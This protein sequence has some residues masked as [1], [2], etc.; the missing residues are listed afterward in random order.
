MLSAIHHRDQERLYAKQVHNGRSELE[1]SPEE[2]EAVS[3]ALRDGQA[4]AR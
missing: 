1:L 4:A 3:R 2:A